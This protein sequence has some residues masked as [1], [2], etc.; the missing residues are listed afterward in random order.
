[1]HQ[2]SIHYVL[3][4]W[5]FDHI[6]PGHEFFLNSAKKYWDKLIV[7][8]ARDESVVKLKW[9]KPYYTSLERIEHVKD[10][11]IADKVYAWKKEQQLSWLKDYQPCTVCLWYDQKGYS[12]WIEKYIEEHNLHSKVV[13]VQSH[14]PEKYK[15]S[16][17]KAKLWIL[18]NW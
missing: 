13:R 9:K 14:K 18:E 4:F 5:T 10:L 17:I 12:H 6:H 15:S 1:M 3:C 11:A 16:K 8:V 7:V 2:S